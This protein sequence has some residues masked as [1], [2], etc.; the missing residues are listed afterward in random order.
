MIHVRAR[1]GK[2]RRGGRSTRQGLL[3]SLL[4]GLLATAG[5]LAAS[6]AASPTAFPCTP[7][8]VDGFGPFGRG[9]PPVRAKIGT[10]HVL[11]GVVL[12]AA[13]C[14]PLRGAH[15][16]L[17]QENAKGLYTRASS[18]TVITDRA[19]ALPVPGPAP[20]FG[21]GPA[22]AHPPPHH[23]GRLPPAPHAL[24]A[25][26]GRPARKHSARARAGRALAHRRRGAN[27]M[28][29]TMDPLGTVR[30]RLAAQRLTAPLREVRGQAVR[31]PRG[32]TG[33]EF[34][35]VKWSLAERHDD[36]PTP[37]VEAAFARGEFLRTHVLRPTWHWSR[38]RTS[39]GCCASPRRACR[40]FN[41]T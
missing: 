2:L 16:S 15:V 7:T 18:A 17:W 24:R 29:S 19:G 40:R 41:A 10:G 9:E 39:A 38:P 35:E 12:S 28:G 22:G 31:L 26:A 23:R 34:A 11:T 27:T 1:T 37:G 5:L 6:A 8:P 30:R 14:K 36:A 32:G 3:V 33:A 20:A 25:L 13:T 4:V 21:R